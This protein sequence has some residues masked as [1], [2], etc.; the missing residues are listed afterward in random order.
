MI[1]HISH[2]QA[3]DIL[4]TSFCHQNLQKRGVCIFVHKDLYLSQIIIL[5]NCKEKDLE[6]CAIALLETKSS[7]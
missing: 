7:K 3:A 2:Y 6:I 4:G 1:H 5:Q